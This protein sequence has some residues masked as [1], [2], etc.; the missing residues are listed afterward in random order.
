M[1]RFIL[2]RGSWYFFAVPG[3]PRAIDFLVTADME[4]NHFHVSKVPSRRE[5]NSLI[6][7]RYRARDS[8]DSTI[9]RIR[10]HRLLRRIVINFNQRI[11]G[12]KREKSERGRETERER[13]F[14]HLPLYILTYSVSLIFSRKKEIYLTS[15]AA[16]AKFFT[17]HF[18]CYISRSTQYTIYIYVSIETSFITFRQVIW[19]TQ[20]RDFVVYVLSASSRFNRS[21]SYRINVLHGVSIRRAAVVGVSF[22]RSDFC[23]AS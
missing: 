3:I 15:Y 8:F 22:I 23:R 16:F 14:Y 2:T 6:Y 12:R 7:C 11:R 13:K 17:F 21:V 1:G 19:A 5:Y 9:L 18:H 10:E 20:S 4:M